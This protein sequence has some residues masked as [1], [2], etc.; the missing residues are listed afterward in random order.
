MAH[1][2][3][4]K[5]YD[6]VRKEIVE[7][8]RLRQ[9]VIVLYVGFVGM[10]LGLAVKG[11]Q[12][13]GIVI[14]LVSLGVAFIIR[15]HELALEA[16][17]KFLKEEYGEFLNT[18]EG[19]KKLP[20]WDSSAALMWY[21]KQ[22]GFRFLGYILLVIVSSIAGLRISYGVIDPLLTG[23][24]VLS[25]LFATIVFVATYIEREASLTGDKWRQLSILRA[26]NDISGVIFLLVFLLQGLRI[27]FSWTAQ[28]GSFQVPMWLSWISAGI[29]GLLAFCALI[30]LRE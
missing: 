28:V 3:L 12:E 6:S 13:I 16:I 26:Y 7:R 20:Q 5:H 27:Y 23:L 24:G 1:E 14:P 10:V 2:I 18:T 4:V 19:L 15:D 22:W 30:L 9:A 25:A 17:R 11:S 8:I 21:G 29:A